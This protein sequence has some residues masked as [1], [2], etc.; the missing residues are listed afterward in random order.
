MQSDLTAR[1]G[2]I[3]YHTIH[4]PCVSTRRVMVCV[5]LTG[6][7]TLDGHGDGGG[8]QDVA[9]GGLSL[10]ADQQELA[11][12]GVWQQAENRPP[13]AHH[14][15]GTG[16]HHLTTYQEQVTVSSPHTRNRSPSAHHIP[17]TGYRQLTRQLEQIVRSPSAHHIPGTGHR[18]LMVT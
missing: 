17:G 4:M 5:R 13:S 12:A 18:Q 10:L 14:I 11:G 8:D 3:A 6:G 16:H 2:P 7:V 15:P 9:G 1:A